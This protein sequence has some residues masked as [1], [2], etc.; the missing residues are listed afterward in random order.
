MCVG[1]SSVVVQSLLIIRGFILERNL[2]NGVSV[3]GS[4][5]WKE[6]SQFIREFILERNLTKAMTATRSLLKVQPFQVIRENIMV[7]NPGR[8]RLS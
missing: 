6:T 7:S 5:G 4:L 3:A 8:H 2:T 1:K